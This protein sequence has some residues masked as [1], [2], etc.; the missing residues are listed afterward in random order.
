L[1]KL[2]NH[3]VE[4]TKRLFVMI[5]NFN[6]KTINSSN[7]KLTLNLHQHEI[8]IFGGFVIVALWTFVIKNLSNDEQTKE[9]TKNNNLCKCTSF[10]IKFLKY[11]CLHGH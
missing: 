4:R 5:N 11:K 8:Y 2:W 9:K 6:V 7:I 3:K 10:N 1:L